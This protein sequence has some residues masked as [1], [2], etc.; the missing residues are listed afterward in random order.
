MALNVKKTKSLSEMPPRTYST[1]HLEDSAPFG[2]ER[3]NGRMDRKL[4]SLHPL[5]TVV[6]AR[7]LPQTAFVV[8]PYA[9]SDPHGTGTVVT[10]QAGAGL[11]P[12]RG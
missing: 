6:S 10:T 1:P 9:G 2:H 12:S 8:Q 5:A 11:G 7:E 3:R 4:S